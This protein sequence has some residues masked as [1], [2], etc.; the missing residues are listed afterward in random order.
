M[1]GW[2]NKPVIE[3]D[4]NFGEFIDLCRKA[5]KYYIEERYPPGPTPQYSYEEIKADL[6]KAWELIRKIRE[7]CKIE[8]I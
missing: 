5:T 1:R 4:R 3:L 8:N 2:R 6:A 7:K